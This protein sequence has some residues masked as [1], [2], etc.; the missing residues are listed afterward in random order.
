MN[1]FLGLDTG[2]LAD[3]LKR[4]NHKLQHLGTHDALS[5]LTNCLSLVSLVSLITNSLNSRP[6]RRPI[7]RYERSQGFSVAALRS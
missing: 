2:S 1:P 6:I 4:A 5:N 3:S 7:R